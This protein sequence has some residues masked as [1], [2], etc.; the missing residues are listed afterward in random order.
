MAFIGGGCYALCRCHLRNDIWMFAIERDDV[1][2]SRLGRRRQSLGRQPG[3]R[4]RILHGP[5]GE[6]LSL[7]FDARQP[8]SGSRQRVGTV[9]SLERG[10]RRRSEYD[11][12]A[13]WRFLAHFWRFLGRLRHRYP[14]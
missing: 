14:I 10:D 7:A 3:S 5:G 9:A 4:I 8:A 1:R 11:Q 13:N 12:A 6:V 2:S